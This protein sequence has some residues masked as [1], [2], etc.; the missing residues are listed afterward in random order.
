[1]VL[2][3]STD[4]LMCFDDDVCSDIEKKKGCDD[5]SDDDR[6]A[7]LTPPF[8]DGMGDAEGNECKEGIS[9][10]MSD[11]REKCE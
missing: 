2:M 3:P 4:R 11:I 10:D 8:D 6:Y 1:M 7:P 9:D 5:A